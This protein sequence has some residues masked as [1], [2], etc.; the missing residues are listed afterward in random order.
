MRIA[1]ASQNFRTVTPHAG[2]T[3]RFLVYEAAPETEPVETERLDL[4]R[5]FAMHDWHGVG[6]HPLDK[7]DVV[8]AASC[9]AGFARRMAAR[10]TV[11]VSTEK[12]DPVE[13][14]KEYLAAVAAGSSPA[15]TS[16]G[17]ERQ[18][19]GG[20]P[21]GV[22][23]G[24]HGCCHTHGHGHGHGGGHGHR[25]LHGHGDCCDAEPSP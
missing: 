23:V 20:G 9:G 21:G 16:T 3:R 18:I 12:S 24:G 14:I 15:P 22:P 7:V 8:I 1:V 13:A 19:A 4:A 2:R 11:A 6:E 10:G 5:E 17:H 25:H